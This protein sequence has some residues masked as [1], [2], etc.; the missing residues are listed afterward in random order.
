MGIESSETERRK[1]LD[2]ATLIL[3]L[4]KEFRLI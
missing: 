1:R 3:E 4:I 2:E